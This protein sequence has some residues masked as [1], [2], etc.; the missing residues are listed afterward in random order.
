MTY[1]PHI[2]AAGSPSIVDP[3]QANGL[4]AQQ[5]CASAQEHQVYAQ[6]R[7]EFNEPSGA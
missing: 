4:V 6:D 3:T 5:E 2:A 1:T 7:G